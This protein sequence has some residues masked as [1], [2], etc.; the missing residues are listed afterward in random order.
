M[1]EA[2]APS[3]NGVDLFGDSL[4]GDFMDGPALVPPGKPDTSSPEVDLFADATFVSAPAQVEKEPNSPLKV[5][6]NL[7]FSVMPLVS[8][9]CFHR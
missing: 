3:P 8:T 6:N 4:L 9:M 7:G 1:T 5:R 2:A